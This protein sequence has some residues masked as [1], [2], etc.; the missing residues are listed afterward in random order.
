MCD[1]SFLCRF[2]LDLFVFQFILVLSRRDELGKENTYEKVNDHH[3]RNHYDAIHRTESERRSTARDRR[4]N[5]T[6]GDI[7]IGGV[8]TRNKR[9]N[10]SNG[11]CRRSKQNGNRR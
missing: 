11:V 10:R 7:D 8:S 1:S 2:S 6:N 4:K 9:N 3:P 5:A